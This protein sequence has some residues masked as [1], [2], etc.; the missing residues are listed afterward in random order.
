MDQMEQLLDLPE[1]REYCRAFARL[2]Q[3]AIAGTT[4]FPHS[5][6]VISERLAWLAAESLDLVL[7][8]E[9]LPPAAW[10]ARARAI[11][12]ELVQLRLLKPQSLEQSLE[13]LARELLAGMSAGPA[14]QA[15]L[16]SLL[17]AIAGGFTEESQKSLLTQQEEINFAKTVA[18][19]QAREALADSLEELAERN[20]AL[21]E[22]IAERRRIEDS[23]RQHTGRLKNLHT[24]QLAILSAGSLASTLEVSI[25]QLNELLPN[26]AISVTTYD[27]SA[28]TLH[29]LFS[30]QSASPAGTTFPISM[31]DLVD[32]LRRGNVYYLK[33]VRSISDAP[34]GVQALARFGGRSFMALPLIYRGD[35]IGAVSITMG[36]IREIPADEVAIIREIV[37]SIAV[38]VQ[39]HRLLATA[40]TARARESTLRE[41]AA[42]ITSGLELELVLDTILD[43]LERVLP[44]ISSAILLLEGQE[45]SVTTT[46]KLMTDERLLADMINQTPDNLMAI[47]RTG[48]PEV[49]PDT[50][51]HPEWVG[52]PGGESIRCWLGVPLI[53]KG[54]SIGILTLDRSEPHSF[55]PEDVSLAMAFANQAAIAIENAR[56]FR[57]VQR[58][59]QEMETRVRER[60]RE[61]QALYGITAAAAEERELE[62]ILRQALFQ[63]LTAFDCP[64]GCI[65]LA[66]G[67]GPLVEPPIRLAVGDERMVAAIQRIPIE[68]LQA[69]RATP[70]DEPLI[71]TDQV[72][73]AEK[74]N[75]AANAYAIAPLRAHGRSLGIISLLSA[76][77]DHFSTDSRPLLTTIADQIAAAVE[78]IRLRR[79]AREAAVLAERDRLA[80]DLH[81]AVT[82]SLYSLSLF[83]EAAQRAALANDPIN[84]QRHLGSVLKMAQQA[85]GELRLMLFELRSDTAARK[86]LA[87]ALRDRIQTVEER[88]GTIVNLH[89]EPI[90]PLP[91]GV[92]EALYRVG[93][94]ALNNALRH[95]PARRVEV[96]LYPED[97][98]LVLIIA[99]DGAG[100]DVDE[101]FRSGGM[102]LN[103]M[104]QRIRQVDGMLRV[105]SSPGRGTRI[106]ARAPIS[107]V[108]LS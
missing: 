70:G 12:R 101:A 11:G 33:D 88:I 58:H 53:V 92:E 49:I 28:K 52:L 96:E 69:V 56:L 72:R 108:G 104:T 55:T 16:G 80:R 9:E 76:Q 66:V 75:G 27:L 103:S 41:I 102:G 5:S 31:W 15:R 24:A 97:S 51:R 95:G 63:A 86:G 83:A 32:S 40:Q 29:L 39:H 73:L 87:E 68:E 43:Q 91:I 71:V 14:A 36:E 59:A 106:E 48:R 82:Q 1:R 57:A 6:E 21:K 7:A 10:S 65:Y 84:I 50:H 77:P 3:Q 13:V 2:W 8:G 42:G 90:G 94:E 23:L 34:D 19:R 98:Q 26:L 64:A 30:T 93:L 62:D 38:A 35:L 18:L 67:D 85:L 47:V 60:T 54:T 17:A 100:F 105:D 44:T 37:D 4:L 99:D 22:E 78:V 45:L 79:H 107:P 81:D 46:R 74:L 25:R 20:R 61:L 89:V